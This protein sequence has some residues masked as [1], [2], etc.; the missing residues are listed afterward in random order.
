MR[1]M[2]TV[3]Y[4]N[5][6]SGWNEALPLG[7]GQFGGMVYG[8]DGRLTIAMNHYEVYYR[9]LHR[10]SQTYRDGDGCDFTRMYGYTFEELKRRAAEMYRDPA[11]GPFYL[12]GDALNPDNMY[13]HYG[14][15]SGGVSHYPTGE[16]RLEVDGTLMG[17][18]PH[19]V[20]TDVEAGEGPH[21]VKPGIETGEGTYSLQLIVETA[22]VALRAERDGRRLEADTRIDNEEDVLITEVRQSQPGLL[23]AVSL[24][25]PQERYVGMDVRYERLDDATFYYRGSF[26]ADGEDKSRYEPFSFV[27]ML[28]LCG[29]AGDVEP[30]DAGGGLRI[31]LRDAGRRL[32]L[33]T[34]VVTEEETTE[35]VEQAR[36]RLDA[37]AAQAD[38]RRERHR[39]SWRQFWSRSS[40]TLPDK[41][42][43]DLWYVNL[44]AIACSSG[45]GGR[46]Y[47]QACGLNGLWDIKKPTKWG[48]MWYWDVNIQAAFWPL[49][50]ANKLELAE[51]FNDGLLSYADEAERMAS[52]FYGLPGVAADYPHALYLSIWPWCAQFLW[53]YYRYSMD[54][55]FLRERA[56][57]LFRRII[58]FF[59]G[60]LQEDPKQ[61]G[62]LHV[63]PDISPEQ[64]PLT[65]NSVCTLA[66]VRYLL[67]LS[68]EA[69]MV[70]GESEAD[71]AKWSEMAERLAPYPAAVSG[72]YGDVWL[73]SEWAPPD[74]HLRHPSLLMPIYP[75][76]EVDRHS[77]AALR[78]RAENTLRYAEHQL[79]YGVFQFGW[80]SCAASRLGRGN[81]ALRLLYEQGIDLSLRC[82]GMFSEETERWMNYCNITNEPLYHPFMME[83]S[84]ELVAAVNEM[85]LQSYSGIIEV[86]PAVPGGESEPE[87]LHGIYE[88]ESGRAAST[89]AAWD[90]CRFDGLLAV[91]AFEVSA[92][93]RGGSASWVRIHSRAGGKIVLRNPYGDG[94]RIC[95]SRLDNGGESAEQP[96]EV[97][98]DGLI[99]FRTAVGGKYEVCAEPA[100]QAGE[101]AYVGT[102]GH[103]DEL[104]VVNADAYALEVGLTA[105]CGDGLTVEH[106]DGLRAEH[107]DGLTAGH[108]DELRVVSAD[109]P[110]GAM[111]RV[112]TE[113]PGAPRIHYA[114]TGRR[115]FLGKDSDTDGSRLL[116]HFT[117]DYYAGNHRESRLAAYRLDF[118][119]G[120]E[121]PGKEYAQAL[122]R[123]IHA[124]GVLGQTFRQISPD[125]RFSA[126]SGIGWE[127]VSGLSAEDRGRPDELRRDFIGG[128]DEATFRLELPKGRYD[129]LFV[130]G[131][132]AEPSYTEIEVAGQTIW[133]PE[134]ILRAGE[135]ATDILPVAQRRDGYADIR[136]RTREGSQWRIN[137]IV[138]NKNYPYL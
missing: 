63:F 17:E 86:F 54:L 40:V 136:L 70:L 117:F 103:A 137:V 128:V 13:R 50:T 20:K 15:P 10:Y 135:F 80:L 94:Q 97:T 45:K 129:L 11:Q 90:D 41:L 116:D 26:Y 28:R 52:Q 61:P 3:T 64:G 120:R 62:H 4:T 100:A 134:R 91:G 25:V 7:N 72:R 108:A 36:L 133:R 104:G 138:V 34:T 59:E 29:A 69:N 35:L 110:A 113:Q 43:E 38:Q 68:V 66:S 5:A 77:A 27:V 118:G 124:S 119:V 88:H 2:H 55:D 92:E 33:L 57:P 115:V 123:Q 125:M 60:Y 81:Q 46:M 106:A 74:L 9:K 42:L 1:K 44:Y 87:R 73:D 109:E 127:S 67:R 121:L 78:Q 18:G 23:P 48:S 105:A 96:Y 79:E 102:A 82:N 75:A 14:K 16:L 24:V 37:Y 19:M 107:A 76:G 111:S 112:Q 39:E 99:T 31:R 30:A 53:D 58:R 93:R 101:P 56:Y 131:D 51:A 49:Y 83:G 12:Y 98:D 65:R 71:R 47:A 114:H 122:P 32:T 85:L 22:T 132:A 6:Q 21:K 8:E 130:T 84:G 126:R 89:Y 95:V